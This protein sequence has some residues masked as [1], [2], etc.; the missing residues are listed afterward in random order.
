MMIWEVIHSKP[1]LG[2]LHN[3]DCLSERG[4]VP[5]PSTHCCWK[6]VG[7]PVH[8]DFQLW[9]PSVLVPNKTY[10]SKQ[11][12]FKVDPGRL[13]VAWPSLYSLGS[14]KWQRTPNET[15]CLHKSCLQNYCYFWF[16]WRIQKLLLSNCFQAKFNQISNQPLILN[17]LLWVI[18]LFYPADCPLPAPLC[19]FIL[20]IVRENTPGLTS[21]S[22]GSSSLSWNWAAQNPILDLMFKQTQVYM[23]KNNTFIWWWLMV[24]P[25]S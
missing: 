22:E 12:S 2:A 18:L 13:L 6:L 9:R 10:L 3:P 20:P 23:L 25:Y 21:T 24:V 7:V 11:C 17:F 5:L 4:Q 16:F 8:V 15:A 1:P 14:K 19:R